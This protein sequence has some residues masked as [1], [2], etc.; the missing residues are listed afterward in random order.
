MRPIEITCMTSSTLF[1]SITSVRIEHRIKRYTNLETSP[2]IHLS[3][4]VVMIVTGTCLL[5]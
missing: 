2:V 3:T 1:M 4:V 5:Y